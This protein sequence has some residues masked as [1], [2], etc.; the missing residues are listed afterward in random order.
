[1]NRVHIVCEGLTEEEGAPAPASG[2]E[3]FAHRPSHRNVR[4]EWDRQA[5]RLVADND[6]GATGLA[7]F[8]ELSDAVVACANCVVAIGFEVVGGETLPSLGVRRASRDS[9][10]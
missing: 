6:Y 9:D 5:P 7:L 2:L 1:M 8:D 3:E 10:S 4:C